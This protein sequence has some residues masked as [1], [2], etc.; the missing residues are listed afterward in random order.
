MSYARILETGY[1]IYPDIN[2]NVVF[3]TGEEISNNEIDVFLYK[4][5]NNRKEEFD[6][7]I[8]HGK[9][10]VEEHTKELERNDYYEKGI[11]NEEN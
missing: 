8:E 10:L 7:R 4:L 6:K 3:T 5:F 2:G 11:Y 1:Y 9:K